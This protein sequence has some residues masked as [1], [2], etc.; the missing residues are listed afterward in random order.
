M[1]RQHITI[2]PP[3]KISTTLMPERHDTTQ[4]KN[5]DDLSHHFKHKIYG[6]LKGRIRLA[7]INRDLEKYV[8][9]PNTDDTAPLNIIDAGGG[10]G[11]FGLSLAA[12]GHPL[13]LC[14]ISASMLALA[15]EEAKERKLT[16]VRFIHGPIQSLANE[17]DQPADMVLCHALLEWMTEPETAFPHINQCLKKGGIL[18]LAFFNLN[19]IIYKNL[20]RGNYLKVESNNYVGM[21]GSLTPINPLAM[22]DV[23]SWC[24]KYGFDILS[25]SGI[26]VFHDYIGN[27][28]LRNSHPD[29]QIDME[30]KFSQQEPYRSLG[31]Y[32]HVV[33]QK[34]GS[35]EK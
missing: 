10:Q 1:T 17:I 4:D 22:E 7:V 35:A 18:S 20:L 11:Q 2:P 12:Q 29:A 16:N 23:F 5:F 32:I 15:R 25:H 19:A 26:R 27:K 14:D 24:E 33:A 3:S 28:T 21:K 31:R 9:N 34:R 13:T 8:G 30:L 6:Q